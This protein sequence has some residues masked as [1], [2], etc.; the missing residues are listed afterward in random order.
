MKKYF[1]AQDNHHAKNM[2]WKY[3]L[4]FCL[5]KSIVLETQASFWSLRLCTSHKFPDGAAP[6]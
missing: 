3:A 2:K 4:S 1:G 5:W 6:Q